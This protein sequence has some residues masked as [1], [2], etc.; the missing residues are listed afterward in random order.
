MRIFSAEKSGE[1]ARRSASSLGSSMSPMR[2]R[3]MERIGFQYGG[4]D[5][6]RVKRLEG[7]TMSTA[8]RNRS[9]VKVAPASAE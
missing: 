8:Q 9:G 5:L 6:S 2:A 1:A 7:P 3:N 4:M